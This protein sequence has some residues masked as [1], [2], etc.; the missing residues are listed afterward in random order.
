MIR[1]I[2]SLCREL[3]FEPL[4]EGAETK[5][6]VDRLSELGCNTVQG[7][8]FSKPVPVEEYERFIP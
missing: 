2:I 4:A 7:Y 8:Y 3:K 1:H 6:Q 5:Q